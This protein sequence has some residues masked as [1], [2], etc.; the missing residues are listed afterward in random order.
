MKIEKLQMNGLDT[1]PT[2]SL[3]MNNA[4]AYGKFKQSTDAKSLIA[5]IKANAEQNINRLRSRN[6]T[7]FTD[8][9]NSPN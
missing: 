4:R 3:Y 1:D 8:N 5:K 9:S 7:D 6:K 2:G